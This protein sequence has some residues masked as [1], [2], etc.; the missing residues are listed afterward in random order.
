VRALDRAAAATFAATGRPHSPQ[1]MASC[2]S[3][4]PQYE[5]VTERSFYLL[6]SVL[7]L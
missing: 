7:T 4:V 2:G 6:N 5:Q 3:V 1:N